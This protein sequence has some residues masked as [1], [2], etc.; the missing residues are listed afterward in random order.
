M[1]KITITYTH[2]YEN[3]TVVTY[4][5]NNKESHMTASYTSEDPD[6]GTDSLEYNASP[7][8]PL[9]EMARD[10]LEEFTE[11]LDSTNDGINRPGNASKELEMV[12]GDYSNSTLYA[13]EN[14]LRT[15][16]GLKPET[17]RFRGKYMT[18]ADAS[19]MVASELVKDRHKA[20]AFCEAM[21][22]DGEEPDHGGWH[23]IKRIDGFF[24]NDPEEFIVAVGYYGGGN[25]S[26]GYVDVDGMFEEYVKA[27]RRAICD[28]TGFDA[29]N[30]IYI[31]EDE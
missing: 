31:E 18:I 12:Y 26:I 5:S 28:A 9:A 22:N 14:A 13:I 4:W 2:D 11:Y 16:V 19:K 27:V 21:E 29:D 15:I 17:P 20:F 23:G 30:M 3:D 6:C 10:W 24:D 25:L 8:E 7:A 1:N